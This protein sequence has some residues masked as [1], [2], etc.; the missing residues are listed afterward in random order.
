MLVHL[1]I[2]AD[3]RLRCRRCFC[4]EVFTL[5]FTEP[6]LRAAQMTWYRFIFCFTVILLL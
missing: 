2:I 1:M 3:S 4:F 6:P 5:F